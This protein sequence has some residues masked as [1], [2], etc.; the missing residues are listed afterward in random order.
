MY[1]LTMHCSAVL[2]DILVGWEWDE[3]QN[4]WDGSHFLPSQTKVKNHLIFKLKY[5]FK[6]YLLIYFL[7][8]E[9]RESFTRASKG[10]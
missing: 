7:H 6:N 2:Q 1:V 9:E 5:A 10:C 8:W 4:R 3:I